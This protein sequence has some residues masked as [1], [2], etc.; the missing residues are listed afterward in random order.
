MTENRESELKIQKLEARIKDL[1]NKIEGEVTNSE[2]LS[3]SLCVSKA[4]V[5][6]L[7]IKFGEV[8]EQLKQS[9]TM[10][11]SMITL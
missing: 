5:N 4:L 6:T 1:N 8:V 7:N 11:K 9:T 10:L 2:K 3:N